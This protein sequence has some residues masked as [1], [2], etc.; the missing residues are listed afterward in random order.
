MNYL[1]VKFGTMA[2]PKLDEIDLHILKILQQDG[3]ITNIQL[4]QDIGLSPA[5]TLERVR[6]LE[7]SGIIASY[8]AVLDG[9]KLGLSFTA[10]I[11]VAL[12]RQKSNSIKRF[13]D[14]VNN[15]PEIIEVLQVTGNFDYLLRISVSGIPAFEKLIGEK[16]SNIEE[17][18]SMQ[19]LVVL[20]T[21]KKS[22]TLPLD[23]KSAKSRAPRKK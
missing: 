14:Q 18:G 13:I 21:L 3:K 19:T 9:D 23:Y 8:H 15:I 4:S 11:Q 5:P 12:D 20:N 17:I 16:L 10:L 1:R 22:Y 6:K 7:N 2:L